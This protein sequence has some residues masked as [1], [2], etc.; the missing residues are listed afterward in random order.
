MLSTGFTW[1]LP[2][3]SQLEAPTVVVNAPSAIPI[4][5]EAL[6]GRR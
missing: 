5:V 2:C 3:E 4:S 6:P 1:R